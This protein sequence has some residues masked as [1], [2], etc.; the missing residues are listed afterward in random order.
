[1][2]EIHSTWYYTNASMDDAVGSFFIA[3]IPVPAN[4]ATGTTITAQQ[5]TDIE[6]YAAQNHNTVY[7]KS[8]VPSKKVGTSL[9][10]AGDGIMIYMKRTSGSSTSN[11]LYVTISIYAEYI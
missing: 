7:T 11:S 9:L 10:D 4:T 6:W 1:M 3:K 2:K 5:I 8:T